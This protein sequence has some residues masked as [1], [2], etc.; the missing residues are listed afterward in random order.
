MSF[1]RDR[2]LNERTTFID[3]ARKER[4]VRQTPTQTP[5]S[6]PRLRAELRGPVI[7]PD[8]AD[9]DDARTVFVGD[10][11]RRP[12]VIVR[13]A[14]AGDAAR[15]IA[16]ARETGLELAARSGGHSNG[17]HSVSEGGIVLDLGDMRRSRSM[18]RAGRRGPRPA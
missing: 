7:G 1:A 6:L 13:V 14:D 5:A 12:A 17:G 4:S 9:Y 2:G 16:T 8:D 18:P 3:P 11:D 15:V 10:I